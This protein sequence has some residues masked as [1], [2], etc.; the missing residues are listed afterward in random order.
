LWANQEIRINMTKNTI[1]KGLAL[2]L[3]TALLASAVAAVP[4]TA[5]VDDTA[6]SL[7]PFSGTQYSMVTDGVFDLKSTQS[8]VAASSSGNISYKVTDAAKISKFDY[9]SNTTGVTNTDAQMSTVAYNLATSTWTLAYNAT[10]DIVTITDATDG[11]NDFANA[12]A[13]DI[14]KLTGI[15]SPGMA[16]AFTGFAQVLSNTIDDVITFKVDDLAAANISAEAMTAG[17]IGES[18][19]SLT[20]D[21]FGTISAGTLGVDGVTTLAAPTRAADGSYVIVGPNADS[22]KTDLLRLVASAAGS[23]T[24]QAWIDEN[25]DGLIDSTEATS[26]ARTVTFVTWANSGAGLVIETPIAGGTWDVELSFNST[27][28]ASQ[29]V[30]TR[31]DLALGV[32]ED[33]LLEA[34]VASTTV[35]AGTSFTGATQAWTYGASGYANKWTVQVA[36]ATDLETVGTT[37]DTEVV[38]AAGFTYAGQL[39][40]DGAAYGNITY[41]NLGAAVADDL[42]AISATRGDNV[43]S[44]GGTAVEVRDEYTGN[45]ELKI[46]LTKDD[47]TIAG[48]PTG[49]GAGKVAVAAG[50]EVTVKVALGGA[51]LDAD[52]TVTS[53]GKTLTSVSTAAISYTAVTDANGYVTVTLSNDQGAAGD[54]LDVTITHAGTAKTTSVIWTAPVAT[55]SILSGPTVISTVAK[56]SW[57]NTYTATDQYGAAL[58]GP[59]YRLSVTYYDAVSGTQK[60]TGVALDASGQGTLTVTDKSTAV[61]N[62]SVVA[63]TQKLN[64]SAVYADF[65]DSDNVVTSSVYVVTSATA[66]AVTVVETITT[67]G[68]GDPKTEPVTASNVNASGPNGLTPPA[69]ASGEKTVISGVV[70]TASGAA[71]RGTAVTVSA[72]GLSF[73][74]G[75]DYTVGSATVMTNSSGAYTVEVRSN[76]AGE[77][78]VTVT[79]G[80]A[81]KTKSIGFDAVAQSVGTSLVIDA[82]A[83][84]SAGSSFSVTVSLKDAFGNPVT[85]STAAVFTLSYKG[86]GIALSVPSDTDTSGEAT[87]AVLL[88]SKDTAVGTI[89]AT[90]DADA[91]TSTVDN[92]ITAVALVNGAAV[93]AQKITVGTY[94]GYVAVFTK[95]YE[96]QKLSVRLASKW[97]VVPTIVDLA[98]GYSL[99]TIN[100]GVGYVANVIVYIDGV[101]V[102]RKTITTK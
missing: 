82:P 48:N 64:T 79:S 101:E 1:R 53:G 73:K 89:T 51:S 71:V 95:G 91:T 9:Q 93:S 18:S 33:G 47:A 60:T 13:D 92:N 10:T 40:L 85:T 35:G 20:L 31:L 102:Q 14:V 25:A 28:N 59:D 96:G 6:I 36:P 37:S 8:T 62:F 54:D 15:K 65:G 32:I 41:T 70:T 30:S 83:N 42:S 86:A 16:T 23:V 81:T 87:F 38:F 68:S 75:D 21:D 77:Q 17:T 22:T 2:G 34:A 26:S 44:S 43:R 11:D 99:K 19:S 90:Y 57:S 80:A 52:S 78:L 63:T 94:K 27:I 69:V 56:A 76:L 5:A 67:A 97:H 45:V 46:L 29:L 7:V 55:E 12:D 58:A 88:G 3:G 98:A 74:S 4:A 49:A 61:G 84:V 50:T 39:F 66:A 100:T 72:P 24:V